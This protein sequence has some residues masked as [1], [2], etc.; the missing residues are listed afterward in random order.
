MRAK[1]LAVTNHSLQMSMMT[2]CKLL[3]TV[4]PDAG[5]APLTPLQSQK[6]PF[7]CYS[8]AL[9]GAPRF[10]GFML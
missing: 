2:H 9:G 10:R 8:K 6:G 1:D 4:Y 5:G 7:A 3:Q